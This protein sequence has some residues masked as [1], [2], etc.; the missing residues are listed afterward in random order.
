VSPPGHSAF[1]NVDEMLDFVEMLADETGLPV[2]IKSAVGEDAFWDD[3]T[4][5]MAD[6]G[7]GVDF[8]T[9]DGGEGGTGAAPLVFTDHVALPFKLG[10][11]RVYSAFARH[12]IDDRVTF[13]GSGKL[14]LPES[15]LFAFALGADMVN[16]AREPMLAIGCLQAQICHTGK[17]PVGITTQNRWLRRAIRPGDKGDRLAA[18]I[19]AL[20]GEL[21]SL[22]HAC[23]V[24]HPS[25][26]GSEHLELIDERFGAKSVRELFGYEPGWGL[27]DEEEIEGMLEELGEGLGEEEEEEAA[28][29]GATPFPEVG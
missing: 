6:T 16:L 21:Y 12:G 13:I 2:G 27:A 17:C 1:H 9:I 7:R 24:A 11:A 10:F 8:V 25:L 23:G 20:R 14:G 5:R 29:H 4:R 19:V 3:L 18:Y 15:A 26:V 22:A 28:A